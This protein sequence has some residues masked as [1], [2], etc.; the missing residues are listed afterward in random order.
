MSQYNIDISQYEAFS[1]YVPDEQL[2]AVDDNKD[3]AMLSDEDDWNEDTTETPAG[4]SDTML[5]STDFL[6]E[7]ERQLI[8]NVAPAEGNRP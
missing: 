6:E 1:N 8:L 2:S 5:T 7:N 4:V 3:S